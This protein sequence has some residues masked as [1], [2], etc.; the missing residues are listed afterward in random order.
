ML[1]WTMSSL[2]FFLFQ[3]KELEIYFSFRFSVFQIERIK[4][5]WML[6]QK[7][8]CDVFNIKFH[9]KYMKYECK[10]QNSKKFGS[11]PNLKF[12]LHHYK[13]V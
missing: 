6:T 13:N 8:E 3:N 2:K 11:S 1:N 9:F 5:K 10:L 4:Q 12:I 7:N